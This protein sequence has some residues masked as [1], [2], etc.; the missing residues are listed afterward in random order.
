MQ[1]FKIKGI[2]DYTKGLE[3]KTYIKEKDLLKIKSLVDV[4]AKSAGLNT[5]VI[6]WDMRDHEF[7]D[8]Y[9]TPRGGRSLDLFAGKGAAGYADQPDHAPPD[10]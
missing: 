10:G 8:M 6:H 9:K 7:L 1:Y 4:Q 3:S 2:K 5:D